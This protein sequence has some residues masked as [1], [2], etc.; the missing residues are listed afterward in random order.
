MIAVFSITRYESGPVFLFEGRR[1]ELEQPRVRF[2]EQ[3]PDTLHGKLTAL[4]GKTA[5][6]SPDLGSQVNAAFAVGR[7]ADLLAATVI[8]SQ[9]PCP[10]PTMPFQSRQ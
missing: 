1:K 10:V 2:V 7:R 3:L 8:G 9:I 4:L 5:E 6:N